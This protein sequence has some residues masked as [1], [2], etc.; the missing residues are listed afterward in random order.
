MVIASETFLTYVTITS[1]SSWLPVVA[2]WEVNKEKVRTTSGHTY[3]SFALFG[4]QDGNADTQ[5]VSQPVSEVVRSR[6]IWRGSVV[7]SLKQ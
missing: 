6:D 1:Q 4:F 5:F 7:D 2:A 3:G